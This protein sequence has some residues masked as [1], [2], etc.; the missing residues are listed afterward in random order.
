MRSTILFFLLAYTAPVWADA[1]LWQ[2]LKTEPNLVVLMRHTHATDG[3]PLTWDETGNCKGERVLSSKGKDHARKVGA[4]FKT[5]GIQPA[6]ISS[7]MCRCLETGR[8]A[9]GVPATTN[10]DL[11]EI[12]SADAERTKAFETA[13][14]SLIASK[15]GKNPVVFVSHRP[16]IN[17]LSLEL[18]DDGDL[19]IGRA[20]AS[21]EIDVLGKITIQP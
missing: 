4:A 11:R 8:L 18:I 10:P 9:F 3:N 21:G 6:V 7:P 12:A 2:K 5:H 19:L 17:K 1:Q 16:N 14:Q 20:R 15:R 13:A